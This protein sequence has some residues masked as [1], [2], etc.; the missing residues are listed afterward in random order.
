MKTAEAMA[1]STALKMAI[2]KQYNGVIEA[3]LKEMFAQRWIS[4]E[5]EM[6]GESHHLQVLLCKIDYNCGILLAI[7]SD[8]SKRFLSR[9]GDK[10]EKELLT[11]VSHWR[12]IVARNDTREIITRIEA[13][14]DGAN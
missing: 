11:G 5:E 12:P 9:S 4:A 2:D 10:T 1:K 8:T 7:W 14:N 3:D 6:P 13:R